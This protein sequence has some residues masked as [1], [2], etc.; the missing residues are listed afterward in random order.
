MIGMTGMKGIDEQMRIRKEPNMLNSVNKQM[1]KTS[2]GE[3]KEQTVFT[4]CRRKT[5]KLQEPA[6]ISL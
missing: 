4:S 3:R 2:T 5:T 1:S 6:N